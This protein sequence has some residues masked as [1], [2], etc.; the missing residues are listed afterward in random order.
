MSYNIQIL[1]QEDKSPEIHVSDWQCTKC[2]AVF[3]QKN[4][5]RLHLRVRHTFKLFAS[6][7]EVCVA[8]HR[9]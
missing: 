8:V 3:P 4:I 2:D 7:A 6:R 5:A 1:A 9:T